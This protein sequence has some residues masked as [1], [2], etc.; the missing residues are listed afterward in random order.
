MATKEN[1]MAFGLSP[2]LARLLGST[3]V[4]TSVAG[5]TL[6]SANDIGP[7]QYMTIISASNAGSGIALPAVGG[8]FS[9][10]V[11]RGCLLNDA[12]MVVNLL[13][14]QI[15]VYASASAQ[16]YFSGVSASGDTGA[17]VNTNQ[18]AIFWPVTASTWIGFRAG[19]A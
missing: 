4:I 3:P 14:A 6:A 17:T 1:L 7:Q 2:F 16:I 5:T 15:Q 19:S 8:D 10:G 13:Q 9:A 18:T 12:F 11:N